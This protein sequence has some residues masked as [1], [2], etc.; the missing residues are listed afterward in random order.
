MPDFST[1]TIGIVLPRAATPTLFRRALQ[2]I[3]AQ[4]VGDWKLVIAQAPEATD[5]MRRVADIVLAEPDPRVSFLPDLDTET[6]A[7]AINRALESLDT[8]LAVIHAE[9][10]SWSPDFLAVMTRTYDTKRALLPGLK[11]IVSGVAAVEETVSGAH[12]TI[13]SVT[14]WHPP[15]CIDD[16][17]DGV[18]DIRRIVVGNPFPAIAFLFDRH[19]AREIGFYDTTLPLLTE[20]EFHQRFCLRNDVWVHTER[21]AFHHVATDRTDPLDQAAYGALLTNRWV[22]REGEAGLGTLRI[23]QALSALSSPPAIPKPPRKDD[24]ET[25]KPHAPAKKQKGKIGTALSRLNRARKRW[26]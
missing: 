2:S 3:R 7:E 20:W 9:C 18:L 24:K 26:I 5:D 22:R 10:D 21:L 19:E 1:E 8:E 4:S 25:P 6:E 17:H 12:I 16:L 11:G 13:D 23:L 15:G 14:D